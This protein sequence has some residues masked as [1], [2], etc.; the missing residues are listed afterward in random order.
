MVRRM[1]VKKI[2]LLFWINFMVFFSSFDKGLLADENI[3]IEIA[4][5]DKMI[6]YLQSVIELSDH[7]YSQY[8]YFY[9]G[10]QSDQEFYLN[11][12]GKYSEGWLAIAFDDDKPIGYAIGGPIKYIPIGKDELSSKGFPLDQIF[13]LGEITL[14]EPYRGKHVGSEM[15]KKMENFA[16][17]CHYKWMCLTQLDESSL[18][19]TA[20]SGYKS[21]DSFWR[22]LG[23]TFYPDLTFTIDWR[24]IGET[25]K[26]SHRMQYWLKTL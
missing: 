24:E 11:L 22:A 1:K 13:L 4:I 8:P 19:V 12:Y 16:K 26:K 6:P 2:K 15:V 21:G 20:P 18:S 10:A 25:E 3:R 9:D 14:L 23:F 7:F 17:E 5:G